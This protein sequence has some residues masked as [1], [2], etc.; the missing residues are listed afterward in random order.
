MEPLMSGLLQVTAAV[1][2]L[3]IFDG[4]F[5]SL[6]GCWAALF[7]Q[8]A[9]DAEGLRREFFEGMAQ[10]L[11]DG[12]RLVFAVIRPIFWQKMAAGYKRGGWPEM[13]RLWMHDDLR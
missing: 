2:L 9:L 6:L 3:L 4:V 7:R 8:R 5:S 11:E 13:Y 1:V 12:A 10:G